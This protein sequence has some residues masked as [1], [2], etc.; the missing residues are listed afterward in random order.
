MGT[1]CGGQY[2]QL[3]IFI[4]TYERGRNARVFVPGRLFK[5]SLM[6]VGTAWS[7]P[8]SEAPERCLL[9]SGIVVNTGSDT[10]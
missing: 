10:L 2:S 4:V 3:F 5:P 6:F 7:L 9:D 1:R 8:Y